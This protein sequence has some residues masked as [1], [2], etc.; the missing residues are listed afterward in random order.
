MIMKNI[1]GKIATITRRQESGQALIIVLVLL[2]V[3]SLI[4]SPVLNLVN[5]SLKN[6]QMYELKTDENYAAK[7]GI[8]NATWQIRN[9]QLGILFHNPNY[10][11]YDYST[12]WSYTLNET[13]NKLVTSV[14]IQNIWLPKDLA[15]PDPAQARTIIESNKLIVTGDTIQT[16]IVLPDT[17]II[18]QYQAKIT[19]F[20]GASENLTVASIG[21][22]LPRGFVYYTDATHKS[23]L[24]SNPITGH[25]VTVTASQWAGNQA[26]IWSYSS[27]PTFTQLPAQGTLPMTADITFYIKA[28]DQTQ[29]N[30]KPY[31]VPWIKTYNG[32]AYGIPYSW[33]ADIKVYKVRSVVGDTTVESYFAKSELRQLQEAISGDYY[34]TGNS[35]LSASGS[36]KERTVWNDP[37]TAAVTSTNIPTD[38]DVAYAFLY[39]SGWKN[40]ASAITVKTDPCNNFTYWPWTTPAGT[41]RWSVYNNSFRGR[42]V[43]GGTTDDRTLTTNSDLDLSSYA[44]G[45]VTVSM[46]LTK[47]GTLTNTDVLYYAISNNAGVSGS[48]SSNIEIFHGNNPPGSFTFQIPATYLTT[49]FRMRFYLTLDNTSKY[50]Y[51]DN[52]TV[53]AMTPDTSVIFKIN[54]GSGYKQVYFDANGNPRQG[55]QELTA[56][57]SELLRNYAGS[58]P[59][60]YSYSSFRDVTTL[61]RAYSKAPVSPA[62]NWT[63]YSTY[64]VG[65]IYASSPRDGQ[66]EDEWA[67][68][69]WSLIIIYTSQATQGHQLYLFDDF[70]YSNQDTDHGVNVDFDGDGHPGG[71]ISGFIVPQPITG[72]AGITV[73]NV[74]SGYTSPPA[75]AITGDG[76]G[77]KAVAAIAAGKVTGITVTDKGQ[78][79]TTPPTVVLTGGGG[80]GATAQA[81]LDVNAAKITTFVGEGDVWYDGDYIAMNG[82]KLWD[83][84]STTSNS[85]NSPNNVFNSTSMGLGSYDGIDIDTLGNDPPNGKYI[86]WASNVLK[87]GDTSAQIDMVTHTDVWNMVYII[88]SFRSETTLGGILSYRIIN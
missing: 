64:S 19:Y 70:I 68:A 28:S 44:S 38:A 47:G 10:E 52:I 80:S 5:S 83:G 4:L 53:T 29:P 48:W 85:K 1:I 62:T 7:S 6:G 60:G 9:N 8:E 20:P 18:S 88:L 49:K 27:A 34:A 37:S 76:T 24:E 40:D 86:T 54:D 58:D 73:T 78:N 72:V 42:G 63:G 14:N 22:W 15:I 21:V 55:S 51:I 87:P 45:N 11:T 71:S 26:V 67:Y 59:H 39:W 25:P 16:G 75:V 66:Q 2:M 61:V 30:L 77:A 74:G 23:S 33:D 12:L 46:T 35:N 3:G 36:S 32:S 57:R 69:N 81:Y 13:I 82:T 43:P 41:S 79:Y 31:A 17:T 84:T 56:G 65:G 50:V